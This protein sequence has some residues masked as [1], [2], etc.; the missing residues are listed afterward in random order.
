MV[1]SPEEVN[2]LTLTRW[3]PARELAALEIDRLNRMFGATATW[4]PPVDIFETADHDVVVKLE[5]PDVKREDISLTLEDNVLT[6]AGE[7][8]APANVKDDEYR[9]R[10][11]IFGSFSRSFTL[12]PSV[13]GGRVHAAYTDGV[14]T[15]TLPQR[16]EAKPRQISIEG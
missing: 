8:K 1:L 16:A 13:D 12:P 5:V 11:R 3:S 6:V 7:R 10:E 14:L 9:R 4:V 2:V 15:I